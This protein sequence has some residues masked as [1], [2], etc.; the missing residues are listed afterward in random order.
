MESNSGFFD[1][2]G[3]P[4]PEAMVSPVLMYESDSGYCRI[5][6]IDRMGRFRVLKGLKPKHMGDEMYETLLRKEF[7]IGYSLQ[8]SHICEYYAMTQVEGLGYC[9][10]MEWVDGRTLEKALADGSL[11]R[12]DRLR[13]AGELCDALSYLHS[14]Q[15]YHRDIKPSNILITNKG[16]HVKLI[17]FGLADSDAHSLLKTPAG[18][19]DYVAPEII[20]GQEA[21]PR[22]DIYSLGKVLSLLGVHNA[23]ARKCCRQDPD[24]RYGNVNEVWKALQRNNPAIR[25]LIPVLAVAAVALLWWLMQERSL[26]QDAQAP[27]IVRD[28]V[29]IR[30]AMPVAEP[31][32]EN[33]AKASEQ[34]PGR[35]KDSKGEKTA[36][37]QK[38][39]GETLDVEA[40]DELFRQATGLFEESPKE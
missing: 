16:H 27:A 17:D 20:S 8:H 38:N 7:E 14:R 21:D 30:D 2:P 15:T 36:P 13:I 22:S 24:R 33:P 19:L 12:E 3:I 25:I 11:N 23:V 31:H 9:I 6:R 32:P 34:N 26:R 10:E 35:S 5:F 39:A 18:T 40:I 28:S 4:G 29:E 37:R 1:S